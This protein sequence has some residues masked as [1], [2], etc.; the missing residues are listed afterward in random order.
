[1]YAEVTKDGRKM[2]LR[3]AKDSDYV[4]MWLKAR[5]GSLVTIYVPQL[6]IAWTSTLSY[7]KRW[8]FLYVRI[9]A[10]LTRLFESIWRAGYPIPIVISIPPIP[11]TPL[12][13]GLRPVKSQGGDAP[14]HQGGINRGA[15]AP[16]GGQAGQAPQPGQEG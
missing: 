2:L 1:V 14:T 5:A 16:P 6:G 10:N 15:P 11:A 9:P 12:K 13:D 8:K 4:T 7:N 3:L